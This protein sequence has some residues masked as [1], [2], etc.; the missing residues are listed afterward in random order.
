MSLL[1]VTLIAASSLFP[2]A[3]AARATCT[4]AHDHAERVV[5]YT[6]HVVAESEKP[7]YAIGENAVLHVKVT[8]PA[9]KDPADLGIEIEPPHSEP[10]ADVSVGVGAYVGDTFLIGYG[11]TDDKGK[12][13]IKIKLKN[14]VETGSADV[15]FYAWK[16]AFTST[17]VIVDEIGY[18]S[19]EDMFTVVKP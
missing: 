16:R 8:R 12:A 17:C 4:E 15:D 5:L 3:A 6:F 2:G 11:I 13:D 7:V 14:Y 18:R 19:Y 1:A 10:V 9:H